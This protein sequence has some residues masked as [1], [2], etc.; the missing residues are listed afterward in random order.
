ML[1]IQGL[2]TGLSFQQIVDRRTA[3]RGIKYQPDPSAR[4]PSDHASFYDAGVPSLFFFT[5]IHADYHQPGDDTEKVNA[6]GGAEVTELVYAIAQDLI[7]LDEPPVFAKVDQPAR[8]N[9]GAAGGGVTLGIMPDFEDSSGAKGWRIGRVFPG[10]GAAK[11]GMKAGDRILLIEGQEVNTMADYREVTKEKKPGDKVAI[12]ILRETEQM[13]LE[14][15]LQSREESG[16][17]A[18]SSSDSTP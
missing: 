6:P 1:A 16:R 7:D 17:R 9:R 18:G 11:A 12:T 13:V 3:E 8:I 2:G 4:G 5:G 14:V 10:G 15:E